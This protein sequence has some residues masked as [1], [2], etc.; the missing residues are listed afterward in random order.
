[1]VKQVRSMLKILYAGSPGPSP[2]ISAK[3][4]LRRCAA[5]ENCKKKH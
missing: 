3:I 4:T 1:M 5:A 2:A